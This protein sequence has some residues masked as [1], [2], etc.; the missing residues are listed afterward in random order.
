M[1]TVEDKLSYVRPHLE[2]NT[3]NKGPV[4]AAIKGTFGDYI[5]RLKSFTHLVK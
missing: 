2:N 4:F 5:L 1:P 3:N